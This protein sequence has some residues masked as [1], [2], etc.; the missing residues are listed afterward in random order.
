MS[1]RRRQSTRSRRSVLALLILLGCGPFDP[2]TGP[3]IWEAIIDFTGTSPII[4]SDTAR[5][6][7][8]Y[9]VK[10][11]STA[12]TCMDTVAT[13]VRYEGAIAILGPR[14]RPLSAEE[15]GDVCLPRMGG[16]EHRATLRFEF[17]GPA[18]LRVEAKSPAGAPV[19]FEKAITV[20]AP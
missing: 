20:A 13:T 5:L 6:G 2:P 19:T 18:T 15:G 1:L 7:H 16:L 11:I 9:L 14:I 12:E 4:A 17:L 10:V 3:T 8:D